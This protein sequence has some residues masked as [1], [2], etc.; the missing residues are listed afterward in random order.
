MT[1]QPLSRV[2]SLARDKPE[3]KSCVNHCKTRGRNAFVIRKSL[4][5]VL[6]RFCIFAS[7]AVCT[8][9]QQGCTRAYSGLDDCSTALLVRW[10]L[11][12]GKCARDQ[13]GCARAH[14]AERRIVTRWWHAVGECTRAHKAVLEPIALEFEFSTFCLKTSTFH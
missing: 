12:R 1:P 6:V 5:G 10:W 11:R 2:P 7:S 3:H 8:W 14:S 4:I 9:A 13:Q